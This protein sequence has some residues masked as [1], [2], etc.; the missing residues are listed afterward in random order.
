V[1][2]ANSAPPPPIGFNLGVSNA[3]PPYPQQSAYNQPAGQ[4]APYPTASGQYGG[5]S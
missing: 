5:R 2:N 3:A 1:Y 4:Y